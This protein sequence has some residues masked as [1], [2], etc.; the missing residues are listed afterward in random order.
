MQN[1]RI[2]LTTDDSA[3]SLMSL[4]GSIFQRAEKDADQMEPKS[5]SAAGELTYMTAEIRDLKA[6]VERLRG[7]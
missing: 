5:P 4:A 3:A 2:E 7:A 1:D 6:E